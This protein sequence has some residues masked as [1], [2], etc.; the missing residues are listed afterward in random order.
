MCG[1]LYIHPSDSATR[2][3]AEL[4]ITEAL[5]VRHNVVPTESIPVVTQ[6]LETTRAK[7]VP[8]RWWLHPSWATDPPSSSSRYKTFNARIEKVLSSSMYRVPIRNQRGI[9]PAAAFVEWQERDDKKI[10]YYVT[11]PTGA[12]WLAAI[13][14]VWQLEVWSCT[15]ITQ[16]ANE[17]F[18]WLHDRMPLSLTLD[19]AKWWLHPHSDPKELIGSLKGQSV[20]LQ[21]RE[22]PPEINNGRNK[23]AV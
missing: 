4:G 1:R 13:W 3:L 16:P 6:E 21:T 20:P 17:D 9:V 10:P 5:P 22:A 14:D 19:Q 2:G 23:I 8:M 12:L 15:I 7:L 11:S 18:S